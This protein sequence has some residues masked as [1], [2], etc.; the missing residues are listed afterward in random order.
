MARPATLLGVATKPGVSIW[1]RGDGRVGA[2]F[3]YRAPD[4]T[5]KAATTTKPNRGLAEEWAA[6]KQRDHADG[7]VSGGE[8]VGQFLD[9]WLREA[10]EPNRSRNTYLKRESAVRVHIKPELGAVALSDLD[11]RRVERLYALMA[12][13]GYAFATR[14][15]I[16]VTLKMALSRAVRWGLVRRN[17]CEMA[18]PPLNL[19]RDEEDEGI[20][21]LTDAQ[22]RRLFQTG[23]RWRHY[24]AVAVRTG[25]RP[26]EMLGLRWGDLNLDGDPGSLR[27]GRSLDAHTAAVNPP[28]S[29]AAKRTVALHFE[30]KEAFLSQRAMLRGERLAVGAKNLVFPSTAGTP[31]SSDNLRKRNLKRDLRG[32]GLPEIDLHGL[33]HSFAS[34]MLHEWEVQPAIV[35]KMMGHASISFT[36]DVYGHLIPSATEDAI[37]SLN[38]LHRPALAPASGHPKDDVTSGRS[39]VKPAVE[40]GE[41][42]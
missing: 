24:Y 15:E 29:P 5:T 20:R 13:E 32:A 11:A 42:G 33:R 22:A 21:H 17:A 19:R 14:R 36:F 39:A 37:R 35:S 8:T 31:M 26:G 28:K 23:S 27:V 3:R 34:I 1:E 38:A 7:V 9:A 16:H 18:A 10:V 40:N 12:R 2:R 6:Q 4:G 41:S 30:A 25:L